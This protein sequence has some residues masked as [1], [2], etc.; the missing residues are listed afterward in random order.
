[1]RF[2]A[3]AL[4]LLALA[5]CGAPSARSLGAALVQAGDLPADIVAAP[6]SE[7]LPDRL[8]GVVAPA[9]GVFQQLSRDGK[10][11]GGVAV[12]LYDDAAARDAAYSYLLAGM[13]AAQPVDGLGERASAVGP[14]ATL[15]FAEVLWVRCRAVAQLRLLDVTLADALSLAQ[16]VDAR[17]RDVAC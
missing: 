2:L 3:F 15:L 10:S 9:R 16:K 1:M 7:A 8:A 13:G 4:A 11:D 17:L 6:V 5:A 12:L 14:E